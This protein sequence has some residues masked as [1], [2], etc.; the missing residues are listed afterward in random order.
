MRCGDLDRLRQ[1]LRA[2]PSA[3]NPHW[4]AGFQAPTPI[5]N[6]SIP[7]FC[8]SEAVFRKTNLTGN[9]YELVRALLDAEADPVI[10]GD[11]VLGSATSFGVMGAAGASRVGLPLTMATAK[12]S[13]PTCGRASAVLGGA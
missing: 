9:E 7:L 3:A 8:V 11:I 6:D 1:I 10:E 13:P 2:R 4:I 5:P 12:M